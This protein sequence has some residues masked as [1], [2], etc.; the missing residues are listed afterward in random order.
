MSLVLCP[1]LQEIMGTECR[2]I[3]CNNYW[4]VIWL[5]PYT[6]FLTA[7]NSWSSSRIC[8]SRTNLS[9][10]HTKQVTTVSYSLFWV[11]IGMN[12]YKRRKKKVENVSY[13][14]PAAHPYFWHHKM[15]QGIFC[16]S[17]TEQ[18]PLVCLGMS[19]TTRE[20]EDSENPPSYPPHRKVGSTALGTATVSCN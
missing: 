4:N 18:V 16:H 10:T 3:P 14:S 5:D 20:P 1:A 11:A 19:D 12:A 8:S 13:T 2:S 7:Y 17:Y 9:H 6:R 15:F